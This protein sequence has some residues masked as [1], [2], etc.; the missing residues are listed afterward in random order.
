MTVQ[1]TAPVDVGLMLVS[2]LPAISLQ[3]LNDAASL[4]QRVDRKYI[5]TAVQLADLVDH[6][7]HRLAALEIDGE[8]SFGYESTYFDT[9]EL[10]S[11][12]D[13]AYR[14]RQ[15]Y[16][17]RTRAYRQSRKAMLEVKTRDGRGKTIKRRQAHDFDARQFLDTE[18]TA[19]VD[20]ALGVSGLGRTLWPLLTTAYRRTTLVDL[21]DV[22]R[23]TVDADFRFVDWHGRRG[24]LDGRFVLETKSSGSPGFTDRYLWQ[25]GARP[26]KISKY[27]TGLAV[28][29][30]SLPS[31]KWHRTMQRHFL[32][33]LS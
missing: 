31:N 1:D 11:F 24:G 15:R 21:D 6:L 33:A 3:E 12:H 2:S 23:V 32:D 20:S 9:P 16:K 18:A 4:Q 29:N 26:E 5:V 30:P 28:L 10:K 7:S 22:A 8:R 27:G 25:I 13:A 19:F 14:R 17:V